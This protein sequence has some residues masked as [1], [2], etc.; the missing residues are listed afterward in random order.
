MLAGRGASTNIVYHAL[1]QAFGQVTV[2]REDPVPKLTFI[3]NRARR[4][5]WPTVVGQLLFVGGASKVLAW[6]GRHRIRTILDENGLD[7]SAIPEADV[8]RVPSVNSQECRDLLRQLDPAVVV[9]NGTRIIGSDTLKCA[10]APFLNMHAGITPRYRGVHGGYWA[11]VEGRPDLMGTTVHLVDAGID[12]GAVLGQ[13]TFTP[14]PGD[15]FATYPYLHIACG[16][17]L[18]VSAVRSV[19]GGEELVPVTS[20][21]PERS[22]LYFHPTLWGYIRARLGR[23]V[24]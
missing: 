16:L 18:L 3:R 14:Q 19:L 5:G 1:C 2:L 10:P 17:P 15:S 23:S 8:K 20:I 7:A 21:A 12:T 22:Q 24:A 6:R 11:R 13:A 9:V 4:L